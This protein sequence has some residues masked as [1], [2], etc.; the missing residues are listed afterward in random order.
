[1][2]LFLSEVVRAVREEEQNEP[3]VLHDS[4]L[5]SDQQTIGAEFFCAGLCL[6]LEH[7]TYFWHQQA[8]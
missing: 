1:V 3:L 7:S 2:V 8:S 4:I 5:A 6:K